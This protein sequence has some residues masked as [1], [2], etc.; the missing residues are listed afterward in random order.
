MEERLMTSS[1]SRI[2]KL[3][4]QSQRAEMRVLPYTLYRLVSKILLPSRLISRGLSGLPKP[5]CILG[6][7]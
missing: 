1:R 4:V 2:Q 6:S 7:K 5:L 3:V